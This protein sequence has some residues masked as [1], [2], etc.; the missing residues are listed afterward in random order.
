VPLWTCCPGAGDPSAREVDVAILRGLDGKFYEIPDHVL[1]SYLIPADKVKE[2]IRGNGG[3]P[4]EVDD[5]ALKT[6]SGGSG[7]APVSEWHNVHAS[8]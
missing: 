7:Q 3:D 4:D 1:S 2:R 6:V 8:A 5:G